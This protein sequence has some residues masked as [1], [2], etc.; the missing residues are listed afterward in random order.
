ML[1][2][3]GAI[4]GYSSFS[5]RLPL[6]ELTHI[7]CSFGSSRDFEILLVGLHRIMSQKLFVRKYFR[8]I[9]FFKALTREKGQGESFQ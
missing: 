3:T 5:F 4:P 6:K 9:T 2:G 7:S 8:L 1:I